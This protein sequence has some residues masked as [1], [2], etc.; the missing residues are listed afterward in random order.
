[1]KIEQSWDSRYDSDSHDCTPTN[2]YCEAQSVNPYRLNPSGLEVHVRGRDFDDRSFVSGVT[3]SP[4]HY[5]VPPSRMESLSVREM[6]DDF[7]LEEAW[8]DT[9]INS[10][11]ERR[12]QERRL[13]K[14][15]SGKPSRPR[16]LHSTKSSTQR[17][18]ASLPR[19]PPAHM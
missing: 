10:V 15:S 16:H 8:I 1:M 4:R 2:S 18:S 13:A 11:R 17:R 6:D 14:R 7:D 12:R 19:R 3:T 9:E 5:R